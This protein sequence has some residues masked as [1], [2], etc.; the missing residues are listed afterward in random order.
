M[1]MR[2]LSKSATPIV[3]AR[4]LFMYPSLSTH[5]IKERHLSPHG[6]NN[7]QERLIHCSLTYGGANIPIASNDPFRHGQ[8]LGGLRDL[9]ADSLLGPQQQP[10]NDNQE[11]W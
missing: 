5:L 6:T 2:S 3:H 1:N 9:D 4:P 8:S 7:D 10:F 11:W